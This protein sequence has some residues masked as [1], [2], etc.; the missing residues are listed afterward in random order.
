MVEFF[1]CESMDGSVA[2]P[3]VKD[4]LF[5]PSKR[6]QGV[7]ATQL[8]S[9]VLDR[10]E[11]VERRVRRRRAADQQRHEGAVTA[12]VCDLAHRDLLRPGGWLAVEM[13]NRDLSPSRR[14]A[15][16][17]TEQFAGLVRLLA[18][19]Q[20]G[21]IE[22]QEGTYSPFGGRR[23]TVRAA[24]WLREQ[25]DVLEV[26]LADIGRD[27]S[28]MDDPLVLRSAKVR[29][30][31]KTLPL[32]DTEEIR[33]LRT[34]MHEIN[35]WLAS[36]DV[37]WV[38]DPDEAAVDP[39]DRYLVRIFNN[40]S[41]TLGGRLFGGFWQNLRSEARLRQV[42]IDGHPVASV[43]F[44]QMGVRLAYSMT[45]SPLPTGDLYAIPGLGRSSREGVKKI[46]GALL[47]ADDLPKRLPAGTRK[48][49]PRHLKI[50]QIVDAVCAF[51]APIRHLFGNG[52]ALQLMFEESRV[53]LAVLR[54]LRDL[55]VVA[56]PIH[57]CV[58]VRRDHASMAK[59]IMEE[60]FF[61]VTQLKGEAAIELAP[62][63][64]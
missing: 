46:L 58:L 63:G 40:G 5:D 31:A 17:L 22:L 20:A 14:R 24:R 39:G 21:V 51:H 28:L 55:G 41:L 53:L 43:D 16:F 7:P 9:A 8:V 52:L 30:K 48:Y 13:S 36:A 42:R 6:P 50:G 57:D 62:S 1:C 34:E 18:S 26:S 25:I 56:L 19:P 3:N 2:A 45:G 29:G 64:A 11:M 4:R 23:T 61:S 27:L 38:G 59:T 37:D 35:A 44:A 54:A 12:L 15:P 33:Q 10:L 32:E 49:F 60:A 47:A